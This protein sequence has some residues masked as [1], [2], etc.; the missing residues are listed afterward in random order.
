MHAVLAAPETKHVLLTHHNA[1]RVRRPGW[2]LNPPPSVTRP[3]I[4]S[5]AS[6]RCNILPVRGLIVPTEVIRF[7]RPEET[8]RIL[9]MSQ[10]ELP[11]SRNRPSIAARRLRYNRVTSDADR[12]RLETTVPATGILRVDG[13]CLRIRSPARDDR[14]TRP[15]YVRQP[16]SG[17]V[18]WR[19][20]S[21]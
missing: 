12:I 15:R 14:P 20:S 21:P 19:A 9:P 5:A 4:Y 6:G 17:G 2:S 11:V 13:R 8:Q 10:L 16:I 18:R 7:G 1:G 3:R